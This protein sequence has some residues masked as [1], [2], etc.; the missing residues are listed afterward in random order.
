MKKSDFEIKGWIH[1]LINHLNER[2]ICKS[3]VK[4]IKQYF[5]Q[6][7]LIW[8][9]DQEQWSLTP[10]TIIIIYYNLSY[11]T[12]TTQIIFASFR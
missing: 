8:K 10:F 11:L 4:Q 2:Y 3:T 1:G 12:K 5:N 6:F 9:L 7:K